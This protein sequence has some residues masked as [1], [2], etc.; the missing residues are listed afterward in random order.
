MIR[1]RES[2][3]LEHARRPQL[4]GI[5]FLTCRSRTSSTSLL[6]TGRVDH[7]HSEDASSHGMPTISVLR[8]AL[9]LVAV[10]VM[11]SVDGP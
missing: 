4:V 10:V 6:D 8:Y 1:P 5:D 9:I 7:G 2:E 3:S 11:N